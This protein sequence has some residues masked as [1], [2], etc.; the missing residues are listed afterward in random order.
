MFIVHVYHK[1][2]LELDSSV[3]L[4]KMFF[5]YESYR[6]N[7]FFEKVLFLENKKRIKKMFF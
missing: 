1:L 6:Q 4:Q 3:K 5:N 2:E 7:L